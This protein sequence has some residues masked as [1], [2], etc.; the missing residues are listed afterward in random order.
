MNADMS[1]NRVLKREA[2]SHRMGG[3]RPK[4][5]SKVQ[6]ER[7]FFLET[8]NRNA[9]QALGIECDFV[10][11]N[12]SFSTR[13]VIRGMHFQE[14]PSQGQGQ[15]KLVFVLQGEIFDVVVDIRPASSTFR[16]WLGVNLNSR[17]QQQLFIPAGFAHGF[18]TLSETAQIVYKVSQLYDPTRER[19]FYYNDPDVGIVWPI[20]DPLLSLKDRQA[21]CL[22][23]LL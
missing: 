18:C 5:L 6:K 22:R 23:S 17:M 9:Y 3:E 20:T 13:G 14:A 12:S 4:H 2:R 10:Q 21:L 16:Q 11:D 15:S 19:S 8:Y 7:G 1:R